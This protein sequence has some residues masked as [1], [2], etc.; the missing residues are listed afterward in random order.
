MVAKYIQVILLGV[1]R[2]ETLLMT[3]CDDTLWNAAVV[4]ISKEEKG[5]IKETI[6]IK[7][8]ILFAVANGG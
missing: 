6:K 5:L 7:S 3:V 8:T 4:L 1:P 2:Y